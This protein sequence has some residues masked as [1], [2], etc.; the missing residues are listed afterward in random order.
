MSSFFINLYIFVYFDHCLDAGYS[1][2]RS[3]STSLLVFKRLPH[4]NDKN[5][6]KTKHRHWQVE[7]SLDNHE[8]WKFIGGYKIY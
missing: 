8:V 1:E 6:G 3:K 7:R 2:G 5:R 4:K